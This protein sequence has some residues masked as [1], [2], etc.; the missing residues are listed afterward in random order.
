MDAAR[1]ARLRE[2]FLAAEELPPKEQETF[3]KVQSGDDIELFE[4]VLSLLAEHDPESAQI[5]GERAIP[6][7]APTL[8]ADDLRSD[9]SPNRAEKVI[10]PRNN[11]S[12]R[13][14]RSDAGE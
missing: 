3:L 13:F 14:S 9:H 2:L 4:E 12:K 5:E 11:T 6:V 8:R 1:Y 10:W 7:P